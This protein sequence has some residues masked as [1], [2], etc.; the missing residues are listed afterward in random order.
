MSVIHGYPDKESSLASEVL[1]F[2]RTLNVNNVIAKSDREYP[3]IRAIRFFDLLLLHF[4]LSNIIE[5][6]VLLS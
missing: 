3:R 6:D 5:D 2:S 4:F 1:A